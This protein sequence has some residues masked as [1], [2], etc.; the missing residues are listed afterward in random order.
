ML[1]G[2]MLALL[3]AAP[4]AAHDAL[5]LLE[6][7]L[8]AQ[9]AARAARSWQIARARE[10]G[11]EPRIRTARIDLNGDGQPDIIATLQTPQKCAAMGL[12]DCPLIVL[13][14]EGNRFVEIGTFFGDEVQMVDQRHQGW[15]AF[16]SRFTNSP[17][18]RTTWNGTMYRLVR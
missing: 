18:R 15:Q 3:A 1:L 11:V 13:K 17:W 4:A 5:P 16:E 8:A 12:R 9:D 6:N 14:A 7:D 10:A 2:A